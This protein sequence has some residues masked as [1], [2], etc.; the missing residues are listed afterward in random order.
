MSTLN[1][2]KNLIKRFEQQIE[3]YQQSNYNEIQTRIEFINP[4]FI[5]LGWDVNNEESSG[6]V[7][8]EDT[9]KIGRATKMPDYSFRVGG[10]RKF[11]VEAKKPSI[12]LKTDQKPAYQLRRYGWNAK[13][14]LCIVTNFAEFAVYDCRVKPRS[15]HRARFIS[16]IYRLSKILG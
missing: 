3:T 6:N 14:S 4:L 15:K 9:L 11:F 13:L 2:I 5:A 12:N 10:K 8:H 1:Q 16:Q 7:V